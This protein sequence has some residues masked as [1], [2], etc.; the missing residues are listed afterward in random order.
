MCLKRQKGFSLVEILIVIALVG[1]LMG[2]GGPALVKQISHIKFSRAVREMA[3]ELNA[4]RL[5]AIAQSRP[6]RVAFTGGTFNMEIFDL[7]NGTWGDYPGRAVQD[8]GNSASITAPAGNFSVAFYANGTARF[9][10]TTD[11]SISICAAN[12]KNGSD[13]MSIDISGTTGMTTV[14]TGC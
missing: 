7:G 1:I 4:A 13:T 8:F 6:V 9:S 5:K 12:A 10:N 11:P 14:T 2:I 3:V